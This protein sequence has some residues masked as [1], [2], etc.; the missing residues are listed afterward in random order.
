MEMKTKL[1]LSEVKKYSSWGLFF[2]GCVIN[3]DSIQ[4][5]I[6]NQLEDSAEN[7]T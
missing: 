1:E 2:F 6:I 4:P 7:C 3:L 5:A